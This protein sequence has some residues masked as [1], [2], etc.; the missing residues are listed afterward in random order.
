M[1]A[2][3]ATNSET[4]NAQPPAEGL[5]RIFAS[6]VDLP[7]FA[8]NRG[9]TVAGA[10]DHRA[11]DSRRDPGRDGGQIDSAWRRH[12][13]AE[14]AIEAPL[15]RECPPPIAREP[16]MNTS[17]SVF[18]RLQRRRGRK[19]AALDREAQTIAGHGID[20]SG[21]IACEEQPVDRRA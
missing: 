4:V 21:G 6:L 16:R 13:R 9:A 14:R 11:K 8:M 12:Q 15:R 3:T 1:K 17:P 2:K 20:E 10:G 7:G 19:L 5:S 18:E